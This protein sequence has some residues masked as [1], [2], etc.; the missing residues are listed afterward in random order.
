MF[1]NDAQVPVGAVPDGAAGGDGLGL[2]RHHAQSVQ[3][4]LRGGHL[5][6]HLRAEVLEGVGE[7]ERSSSQSLSEQR[8]EP[9]LTEVCLCAFRGIP[10]LEDRRR[11]RW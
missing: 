8:S 9:G 1:L 7:S 6:S 11:R 10:S 2:D 4:D 5:R 3:L